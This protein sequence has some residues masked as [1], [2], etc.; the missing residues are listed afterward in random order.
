MS[1]PH[2]RTSASGQQ[3]HKE[4]PVEAVGAEEPVYMS[5]RAIAEM[6]IISESRCKGAEQFQS[7][8]YAIEYVAY[9]TNEPLSSK[10][11]LII[12]HLC[13]VI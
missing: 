8:K 2:E 1:A 5:T 11:I 10:L 4:F 3:R 13:I 6:E 9:G 12:H 7:Q